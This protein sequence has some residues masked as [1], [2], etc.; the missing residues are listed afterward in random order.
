[1]ILTLLRHG[2][3]E[4]RVHTQGHEPQWRHE[5]Q[6]LTL[7]QIMTLSS[8]HS[9]SSWYAP[10]PPLLSLCASSVSL[11]ASLA[12][13]AE[14]Q[15]HLGAGHD[16]VLCPLNKLVRYAPLV[17][18]LGLPRGVP[19]LL[20]GRA[21]VDADAAARLDA[22]PVQLAQLL[23]SHSVDLGLRPASGSMK[24]ALHHFS[25]CKFSPQARARIR[26]L[27][28]SLPQDS[29]SLAMR[30]TWGHKDT[31]TVLHMTTHCPCP[32]VA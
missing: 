14:L 9:T 12:W 21:H 17:R 26:A 2:T 23:F 5:D 25:A 16:F 20:I 1:M 18:H 28:P 10:T 24:A 29:S 30:Y 4:E 11:E 8:A 32:K 13:G 19:R 6:K 27:G 7:A 31:C 22:R 15:A 3:K